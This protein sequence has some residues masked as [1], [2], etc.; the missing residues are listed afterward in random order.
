MWLNGGGRTNLTNNPADDSTPV[1][2]PN[3][4]LI[5]FTSNRDGR[6]QIFVMN[7]DGTNLR[8]LSQGDTPDF[9]PTWSPDGNWIAFASVRNNS[10][11]IYMMDV[12]G[13]NVTRLTTTGGDRPVW[14]H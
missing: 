7:A 11:D 10:T 8:K 2:S 14:S 12:N 4:K 5:A 3:G 1:W 9:E 6:P 13:G